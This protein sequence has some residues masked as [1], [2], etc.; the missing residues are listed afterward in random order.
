MCVRVCVRVRVCV[1]VC[2][3]E[4]FVDGAIGSGPFLCVGERGGGRERFVRMPC[5]MRHE[6]RHQCLSHDSFA[7]H[8]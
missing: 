4:E 5:I 1:C 7:D 6:D 3:C 8:M 2:V